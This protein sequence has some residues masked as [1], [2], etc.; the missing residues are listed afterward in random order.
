[1]AKVADFEFEKL[2]VSV[3]YHDREILDSALGALRAE[4]GEIDAV[5][6]EFSF[7][8]GFSSYYDA[9][10][11]GEG[12]R[13]IYSFE[14]LV[15]P[16]LQ[17]DIKIK[18]NAVEDSFSRKINLDPGLLNDARLLLPTTKKLG[19]RVPL[20]DGIYSDLALFYARGEF[21]KLPWTYRDYQSDAVQKFLLSVRKKF[22]LERRKR[23]KSL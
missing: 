11:G 20:K 1:M 15:S 21:H 10:L 22:I 2:I 9:E 4:F 5:S 7:S 12:F 14:R 16:D 18:T 8:E 13:R 3:I 23:Q 17:A 19:Y 6:T